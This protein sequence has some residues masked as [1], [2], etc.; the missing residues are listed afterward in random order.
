MKFDMLT[1]WLRFQARPRR[2]ITAINWKHQV[3]CRSFHNA[4][5]HDD[6][7]PADDDFLN[8]DDFQHYQESPE[9]QAYREEL[10]LYNPESGAR[11][12]LGTRQKGTTKS[13]KND[14][15]APKKQ[16]A[17]ERTDSYT[18][19]A[20]CTTKAPVAFVSRLSDP[21][22]NLAIEDYVYNTMPLAQIG[23]FN[24]LMFYVNSPCV[25][26]GKNQ[27]PWKEVNLPLLSNLKLPLVRRRSGG[28]TVV[29][30][31]GN[32]NYSFMTAKE[33]FD[34]FTF[35]NLVVEAVNSLDPPTKI[36]VN[37]RG[38][39]ITENGDKVSGS[40]YKLSR[41]KSY[42]HGTMLLDSKLDVLR[43]LL[44]RDE[45]LLGH[46]HS[47]SAV[48]SVKSPVANLGIEKEDFINVVISKFKETY[49]SISET[50]VAGDPEEYD[51][52]E[53]L[54]LQGFVEA[55]SERHCETFFID[56]DV[57]LP[58]E[59]LTVR[60][61]LKT[62]DWK[63]GATPKF[64]HRFSHPKQDL[65]VTFNIDKKGVVSGLKV[66][67][68]STFM[69]DSFQ[70]L[71]QVVERGDAVQYTGSN[72]AGFILDDGLSEWLGNAIDGSS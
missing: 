63:F 5:F 11:E 64:E 32:V 34:R 68:E 20:L 9:V 23:H 7:T 66:V 71:Q 43:K 19:A 41:G 14:E 17:H 48:A 51:Q 21:Y 61:E 42:H 40:A 58:E 12:T 37:E 59:I 46:V 28:G 44:H 30:D 1:R 54:G 38:D 45:S 31:F 33:N 24:R 16:F 62:W 65:H 56:E 39:I 55:Y 72:V 49:G 22:L 18:F 6:L 50:S 2:H 69:K 29:H 3:P 36:K 15:L 47:P 4:P 53:L 52:T 8:L 35:A 60:D 26:I 57:E 70:F 10:G 25:V 67:S 27:N 13:P